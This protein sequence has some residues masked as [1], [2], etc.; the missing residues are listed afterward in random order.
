LETPFSVFRTRSIS[1][2]YLFDGP[3]RRRDVDPGWSP[4]GGRLPEMAVGVL[5]E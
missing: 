1:V 3:L 5:S 4:D 2:R